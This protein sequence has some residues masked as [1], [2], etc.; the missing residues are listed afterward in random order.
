MLQ[1]LRRLYPPELLRWRRLLDILWVP[2]HRIPQAPD[3]PMHHP[4]DHGVVR[5]HLRWRLSSTVP[6]MGSGYA[7]FTV[8]LGQVQSRRLYPRLMISE[9]VSFTDLLFG[10]GLIY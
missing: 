6:G 8:R 5:R 7:S 1:H 3:R 2:S 10:V 4:F 9:P